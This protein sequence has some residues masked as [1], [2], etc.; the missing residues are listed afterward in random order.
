MITALINHIASSPNRIMA[1]VA[2]CVL[3]VGF[4]EGMP[5]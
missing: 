1:L 3:A 2:L 4:I 5:T